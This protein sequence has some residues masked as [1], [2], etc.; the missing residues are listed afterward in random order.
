MKF[1]L[2]A[3]PSQIGNDEPWNPLIRRIGS[4]ALAAAKMG[5]KMRISARPMALFADLRPK[6][7]LSW[8]FTTAVLA[9]VAAPA[10]ADARQA[11]GAGRGYYGLCNVLILTQAGSCDPPSTLPFRVPA[12]PISAALLST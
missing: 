12:V 7:A 8:I 3:E 11:G 10:A 1:A 5:K 2:M 4:R 6:R 9:A